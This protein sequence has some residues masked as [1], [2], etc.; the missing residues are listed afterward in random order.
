M[1]VHIAK[2]H[3]LLQTRSFSIKFVV[4]AQNRYWYVGG[5]ELHLLLMA[6]TYFIDFPAQ[7]IVDLREHDLEVGTQQSILTTAMAGPV[8]KNWGGGGH[9]QPSPRKKTHPSPRFRQN[10]KQTCPI[11]SLLITASPPPSRFS[12]LPPSLLRW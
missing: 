4:L 5:R 6:A 9:L 8:E 11:K 1:A 10:L 7:L 3:A 12:V 2:T